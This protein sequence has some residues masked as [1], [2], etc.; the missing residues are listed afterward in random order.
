MTRAAV[1][2]RRLEAIAGA[3]LSVTSTRTYGP[4]GAVAFVVFVGLIQPATAQVAIQCRTGAL[5]PQVNLNRQNATLVN[6]GTTLA[7]LHP[8]RPDLLAASA[9]VTDD[10][11]GVGKGRYD[12][13]WV[14]AWRAATYSSALAPDK[15]HAV[16]LSLALSLS[17]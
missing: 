11:L 3:P 5:P 6:A 10:E 1:T 8:L 4:R 7:D 2:D 13:P 16:A 14:G 12:Q 15:A 9:A 17:F